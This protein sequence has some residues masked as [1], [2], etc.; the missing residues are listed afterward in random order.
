MAVGYLVLRI[1]SNVSVTLMR[2][3]GM[4]SGQVV[5]LLLAPILKANVTVTLLRARVQEWAGGYWRTKM[6]IKGSRY[7]LVMNWMTQ[8]MNYLDPPTILWVSAVAKRTR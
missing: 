4:L 3:P 1:R 5:R 7:A 6:A 8:P 2:L